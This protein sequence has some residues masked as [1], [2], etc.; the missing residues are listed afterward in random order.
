MHHDILKMKWFWVVVGG[1]LEIILLLLVFRF[2]VVMGIRKANFNENWG[3][4]YGRFF[5][6]PKPG[7]FV[8]FGGGSGLRSAFGN[9]GTVISVGS[10]TIVIKSNDNNEKTIAVDTSTAI[11][12][13]ASNA[14]IGDIHVG[15]PLVVIGEPSS[16]GEIEAKLIRIFPADATLPSG[17]SGPVMFYRATGTSQ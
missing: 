10:S 16:T 5:G 2:G 8:S 3:R 17:G 6:E 12:A 1:I 4:N 13:G 14:T 15:D 11:R 7:F 9:A